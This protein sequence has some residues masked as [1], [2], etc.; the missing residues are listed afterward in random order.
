MKILSKYQNGLRVSHFVKW[1]LIHYRNVLLD[2]QTVLSPAGLFVCCCAPALPVHGL[3]CWHC[4]M[5]QAQLHG[6]G[7]ALG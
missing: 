2:K 4:R 3:V 1:I 5:F 6:C 7:P